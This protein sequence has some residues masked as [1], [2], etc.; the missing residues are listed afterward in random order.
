MLRAAPCQS[1]EARSFPSFL[2]SFLPPLLVLFDVHV[3][4]PCVFMSVCVCVLVYRPESDVRHLSQ[5]FPTIFLRQGLLLD[6]AV[7]DSTRQAGASPYTSIY[8]ELG[9]K[10]AMAPLPFLFY[11]DE[12]PVLVFAEQVLYP[13]TFFLPTEARL[14][15]FPPPFC[16]IQLQ[17]LLVYLVCVGIFLYD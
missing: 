2:L 3:M 13:L 5:P 8:P 1:F 17:L 14:F 15:P 16:I 11:G 4:C 7:T 12:T 6:L 9:Y 10:Q